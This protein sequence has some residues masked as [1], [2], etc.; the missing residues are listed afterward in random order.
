M[1]NLVLLLALATPALANGIVVPRQESHRALPPVRLTHQHVKAQVTDRAAHVTVRQTFLNSTGRVL[2]GTYLFPL[3]RGASVSEFAMTMGGK[4]VRGE[5]LDADKARAIYESIVRKRKDPGLLEYCGRNVYRARVFPIPANGKVE[6]ELAFDQV[7]PEEGG[8]IEFQYPLATERLNRAPIEQLLVDIEYTGD[9]PLKSVYSPSHRVDV[10]RK[11]NRAARV[12]YERGRLRPSRNLQVYFGRAKEELGISVLSHKPT[13]EP[14]T[15]LAAIGFDAGVKPTKLL[16]RD[17]IYVLDTSG[18]MGGD[19]MTQAKAALTEAVKMLRGQDRFG[20]IAFSTETKAFKRQLVSATTENKQGAARWIRARE[21]KGGTAIRDALVDAT[22]QLAKKGNL[23]IVVLLTDGR[24]TIGPADAKT[25]L[26]DLKSANEGNARVFTFGIGNDLDVTL[27]DRIAEAT[28][29]KRDYIAPHEEIGNVTRRFFT[30]IDQ[31][32]VTDVEIDASEGLTGIYPRRLGELFAADQIV[33][34]GRYGKSGSATIT[35]R[36]KKG[37]EPFVRRLGELF[38]ADQIVVLGRYGK[39]G[40]AT[41]TLRG[42]KGDEPFVRTYETNLSATPRHESL[43]RL[44]VGPVA[45][46][47]RVQGAEGRDHPVGQE[48]FH[49]DAVH[50]R[51]RGGGFDVVEQPAVLRVAPHP[52]LRRIVPRP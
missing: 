45:A 22:K 41:I 50:E 43:P 21:A 3:P 18:S 23:P 35:L 32:V 5:V 36:G 19:K 16:A 29:G 9:L 27:L 7:L 48:V 15:F 42:K 11:N 8:A 26:R 46:A 33:V 34:L 24:P 44:P 30:K 39:S 2:E 4:M 25:I 51:P 49:R 52:R 38:A 17:V 10:A 37:D 14:G 47:R 40:S 6:I 31:P 20:I 28:H 13:G 1:R 12:T